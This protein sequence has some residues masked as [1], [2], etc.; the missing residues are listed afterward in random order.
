MS[1]C[2]Y[3]ISVRFLLVHMFLVNSKYMFIPSLFLNLDVIGG[4]FTI[5]PGK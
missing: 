4:L 1:V 3:E 2:M 5:T